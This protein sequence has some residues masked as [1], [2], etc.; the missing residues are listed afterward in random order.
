MIAVED[1]GFGA[2]DAI[3]TIVA[4]DTAR[5]RFA[6]G[7]HDRL[8]FAIHAVRLLAGSAK[9]RSNDEM[10]NLVRVVD[11][12]AGARPEVPDHRHRHA[13]RTGARDGAAT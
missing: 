1:V 11:V 2:P 8:L 5:Q 9:D 12:E 13:H 6:Y 10:A 3:A 4:L 7:S